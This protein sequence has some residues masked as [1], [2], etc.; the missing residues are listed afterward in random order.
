[1][2]YA[3][4]L[5]PSVGGAQW[6]NFGLHPTYIRAETQFDIW[7]GGGGGGMNSNNRVKPNSVELS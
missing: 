1:M 5:E 7:W 3:H 6:T 2:S 4:T